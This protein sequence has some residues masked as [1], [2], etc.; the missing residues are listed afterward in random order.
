MMRM[1]SRKLWPHTKRRLIWSFLSHRI[2]KHKKNAFNHTCPEISNAANDSL[3]KFKSLNHLS[4]KSSIISVSPPIKNHPRSMSQKKP[5]LTPPQSFSLLTA[6]TP[7]LDLLKNPT[8]K[9]PLY[10]NLK[11]LNQF[12]I[13]SW[14]TRPIMIKIRPFWKSSSPVSKM[15]LLQCQ[16][17]Y[18]I[19]C[20]KRQ[21]TCRQKLKKN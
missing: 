6:W 14:R 11:M 8:S 7:Q 20:T 4:N 5:L 2:S 21:S 17:K 16:T 15:M 10:R 3:R 9:T 13:N 12:V 19:N 1:C 18:S